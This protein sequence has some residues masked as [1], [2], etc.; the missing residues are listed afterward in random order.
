MATGLYILLIW[1][2]FN[3]VFAAAMYFR[4]RAKILKQSGEWDAAK[5][6]RLLPRSPPLNNRAEETD[7]RATGLEKKIK[8][9]NEIG[10]ALLRFLFFGLFVR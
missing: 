1:F 2:L 4:P 8:N 5:Q 6:S 7:A 10:S 9:S 3:A